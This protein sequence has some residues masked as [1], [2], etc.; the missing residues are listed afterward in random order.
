MKAQ[1]NKNRSSNSKNNLFKIENFYEECLIELFDER[2]ALYKSLIKNKLISFYS[3]KKMPALNES[4]EE[5]S[6]IESLTKLRQIVGGRFQNLKE[7]WIAAGFPLKEVRNSKKNT[8]SINQE[9]W[10][11]LS[12]WISNHGFQVR[13]NKDNQDTFFEIKRTKAN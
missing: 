9:G 5:W 4:Q 6:G 11:A 8:N 7:K 1:K 13:L 10:I 3:I 2:M 12:S